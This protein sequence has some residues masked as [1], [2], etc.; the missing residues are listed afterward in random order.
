MSEVKICDVSLRDGMQVMN[1]HAVIPL[2][3]RLHLVDALIRANVPYIE[4]G[5]FVNP[6]VVP[7]MADTREL[8]H[9]MPAYDGQIACLVPNLKYYQE[10]KLAARVNTVALFVSASEDYARKNT[11]MT[12]DE[13]VD[14][15]ARV[16]EAA[17]ADGHRLRGYLSFAFRDP[18]MADGLQPVE[19][20]E[21]I[22][23]RLIDIGCEA[24]ALSD[25]DGMAS[26]SDL[27][28][29]IGHVRSEI[30]LDHVAV[31]LHD[32]RGLGI[33]N[34]FAAYQEGVR[35]FDSSIGGIGGAITVRH[36]IG[37]IST[38]ELVCMFD[39]IDVE[40][41]VDVEPLI[42]AGCRVS[43][44]ADFVGDPPPPSRI[45]LDELAKR[46]AE[47]EETEG[48]EANLSLKDLVG[49]LLRILGNPPQTLS[50]E[51]VGHTLTDAGKQVHR[52]LHA[53]TNRAAV[54]FSLALM[55]AV[56][57][58]GALFVRLLPT[59]WVARSEV[60][61][62]TLFSLVMVLSLGGALTMVLA[63]GL[64]LPRKMTQDEREIVREAVSGI[65]E[66]LDTRTGATSG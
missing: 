30:G 28:R 10:L 22:T 63:R 36:S 43:Q 35:I 53:P 45:I 24:V 60:I 9:R 38:E 5:S 42:E 18:S 40:T 3:A 54:I 14:A 55:I 51:S 12:V 31:H 52:F 1:R 66:E 48:V 16:A 32:R 61:A 39:S 19:Q 64:R 13:A 41:G 4:V 33:T 50:V 15:A 29:V 46:R 25:T 23:R 44:M 27:Q 26:P 65:L 34:A 57:G 2:E 6:R 7:A 62:I 37:N 59:D 21:R 11:R 56:T 58:V 17:L 8:L 49:S 20:I 47:V